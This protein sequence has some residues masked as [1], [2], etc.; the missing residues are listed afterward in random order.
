V[1]ATF[2]SS[3]FRRWWKPATATGASGTA[4]VIWFEELM[5]FATEIV[6][7]ISIPILAGAI[8][9]LNILMFKTRMPRK[10]K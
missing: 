6:T 5:L 1:S 7:L 10:E 8:Y 9:L 3:I 4:V 2:N